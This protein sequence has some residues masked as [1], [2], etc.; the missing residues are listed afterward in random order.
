M[1]PRPWW[2]G[3]AIESTIHIDTNIYEYYKYVSVIQSI[4]M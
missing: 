3:D 4:S 1:M 2:I